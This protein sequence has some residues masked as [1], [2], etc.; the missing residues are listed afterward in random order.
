MH[1]KNLLLAIIT[2]L[3][4]GG[5]AYAAEEDLVFFDLSLAGYSIGMTYDEATAVRPFHYVKNVSSPPAEEPYYIATVEHIYV[6]NVE[7][8]LSVSFIDDKV[9][10][11]IGKFHPSALKDMTKRLQTALGP[12]ENKSRVVAKKDGSENRQVIYRWDFPNAKLLLVGL[13]SNSDFALVSLVLKNKTK[14]MEQISRDDDPSDK[15]ATFP[16]APN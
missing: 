9:K 3:L 2:C 4:F 15:T 11:I 14:Q 1:K 7:M 16:S 5:N 12:G 10:K 13:S 6:D 8:N